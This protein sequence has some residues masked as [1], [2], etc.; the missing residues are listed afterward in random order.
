MN[1]AKPL[2][3]LAEVVRLMSEAGHKLVVQVLIRKAGDLMAARGDCARVH[4]NHLL[5]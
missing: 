3:W 2:R 1:K 5:M 4:F